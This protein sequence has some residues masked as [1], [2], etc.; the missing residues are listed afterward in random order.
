MDGESFQIPPVLFE[1]LYEFS[2]EYGVHRQGDTFFVRQMH[3][4]GTGGY[5]PFWV[6]NKQGVQQ[7]LI[8]R[9]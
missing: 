6:L 1:D 2:E 8:W 3:S 7:R 5:E 9:A 4:D